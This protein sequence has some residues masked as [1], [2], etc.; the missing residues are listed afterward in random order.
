M[1]ILE[2]LAMTSGFYYR[3]RSFR[4]LS[5]SSRKIQSPSVIIL[6]IGDEGLQ[7]DKAVNLDPNEATDWDKAGYTTGAVRAGLDVAI[8]GVRSPRG[9]LKLLLSQDFSYPDGYTTED[10]KLLGG[11]HCLP[12]APALGTTHLYYSKAQGDPMPNSIWDQ[13]DRPKCD[14]RGMVKGSLTPSDGMPA[15][16]GDIYPA[17]ANNLNALSSAYGAGILVARSWDWHVRNALRAG[18]RLLTD[19]EFTQFAAGSPE[20]TNITGSADPL[21]TGMPVDTNGV[22]ILSDIGMGMMT[23]CKNQWIDAAGQKQLDGTADTSGGEGESLALAASSVYA[24]VYV[25]TLGSNYNVFI[26]QDPQTGAYSLASTQSN[27]SDNPACSDGSILPIVD[28]TVNTQPGWN[29]YFDD[30]ATNTNERFLQSEFPK[31]IYIPIVTGGVL[32]WLKIKYDADAS[33]KG[34]QLKFSGA[35]L[36]LYAA[37]GAPTA[38]QYLMTITVSG[39]G[40]A[41]TV[42]PHAPVF[43][44]LDIDGHGKVYQQADIKQVAGGKHDDGANAGSASRSHVNLRN[45][46]LSSIGARYCCG[47]AVVHA[48]A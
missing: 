15:V 33:T 12:V 6:N 4:L 13:F 3:N 34:V 43:T 47:P 29:V 32:T 17:S 10:S 1:G 35:D 7:L 2:E 22:S 41:I 23:G 42:T 26:A 44:N 39:G 16:W 9:Y 5:G 36:K 30:D 19:Q 21:I 24:P 27:G 14:P 11:I 20:G 45:V 46:K 31:D 48:I 40:G 18:K 38:N 25:A 37:H 8:Y 28:G